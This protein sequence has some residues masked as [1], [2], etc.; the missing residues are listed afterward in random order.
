VAVLLASLV[1]ITVNTAMLTVADQFHLVTARGSLLTLL[2]QIIGSAPPFANSYAFKQAFHVAVSV[3]MIGVYALTFARLPYSAF[4]KGLIYALIVWLL[5]AC[6]ILPLIGQG[7]AGHHVLH[8]G[9][10]LYFAVAHTT[11]FVLAAILYQRW[12]RKS[13]RGKVGLHAR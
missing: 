7:F 12:S 5:N 4:A 3:P 2:L 13:R 11:F 1:A 9:G 8:L 10:I 6:L